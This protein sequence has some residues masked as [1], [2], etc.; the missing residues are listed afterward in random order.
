MHTHKEL[1]LYYPL[2][3]DQYCRMFSL[4]KECMILTVYS[5]QDKLLFCT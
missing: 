5:A 4:L 1:P 2:K 3:N